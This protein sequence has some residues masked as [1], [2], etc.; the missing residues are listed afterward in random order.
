MEA[1]VVVKINATEGAWLNVT[2][3]GSRWGERSGYVEAKYVELVVAPKPSVAAAAPSAAVVP[4]PPRVAP[5]P[6]S[7]P[8]APGRAPAPI[9]PATSA[10]SSGAAIIP[11]PVSNVTLKGIRRVF[12]EKMPSDLDQYIGA[13]ITKQFK[14][15]LIV[16]L[17]KANADAIMRGIAE[18]QTG[19]GAAITGRY[20]G[21]HDNASASIQLIDRDETQ[22]L[23]ASEAGDRS[24]VWGALAR[25]G[26]R[27]VAARL[28]DNLKGALK[29]AK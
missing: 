13:E 15:Q 1:G 20:L 29:S 9:A 24:L 7:A 5:S 28:V 10:A 17:D 11:R 6:V 2:V 14:G 4:V 26:Q 22:V 19:V 18:N 21:L 27:K 3:S 25:G 12:I 23:W 8:P 16:V